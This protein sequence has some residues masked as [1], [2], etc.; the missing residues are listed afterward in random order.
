MPYKREGE[1]VFVH[2]K[3]RWVL[4]KKHATVEQAKK[5]LAAIH[6]NVRPHYRGRK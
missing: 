2:R 3:G 6:I 5:H 1:S 4:L